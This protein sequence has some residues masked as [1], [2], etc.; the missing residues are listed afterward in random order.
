QAE[1]NRMLDSLRLQYVRMIQQKVEDKWLRPPTVNSSMSCEVIVKQNAL[2][3]V[4]SVNLKEC[5]SDVAFQNSIERAVKMAAPLP[6]PPN[7]EV[8]EDEIHFTF[9]PRS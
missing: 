5:S 2:G 8:F 9:R 1:H 7:P 3:D 4:L 6:A